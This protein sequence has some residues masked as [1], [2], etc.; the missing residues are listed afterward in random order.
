MSQKQP[1]IAVIGSIIMDLAVTTPRVPK[2][3]ENILAH[4]LSIGP[5]G[6]GANASVALERLGARSRL[7]GR[8]GND[9]FGRQELEA[10]AKEGVIVDSV[11]V[12]ESAQTGTALIMVDDEGENTI[13]VVIGANDTLDAETALGALAPHWDSLGAVLVN[14]EIPTE[15]VQQVIDAAHHHGVPVVVDAG[16]PRDHPDSVWRHATILSPNMLETGYLVGYEVADEAT[17]LRAARELIQQGPKAVVIKMGG[18]GSMWVT[19]EEAEQVP[20]FEVDVVDTTGAG[21]AYTAALTIATAE[22]MPLREA[23]RLA[24]AAGAL[25][26]TQLGTMAAMPTRQQ[27]ERFLQQR[28]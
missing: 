6:K 11:S 18:Q 1:H 17:A 26:V 16:P 4:G 2:R 10:V 28:G 15:V 5:G 3:G 12:D 22:G 25:A 23:V 9:D 7:V 24:T 14:F 27:A 19:A 8:V 13:L 21:D 20:A